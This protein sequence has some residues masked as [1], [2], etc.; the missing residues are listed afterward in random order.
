M[1]APSVSF[2]GT[3]VSGAESETDGGV[4]DEWDT[5]KSP[6]QE[7]DFV[8]SNSFSI[9]LKVGTSMNGVEL[10]ATT[11]VDYAAGGAGGADRVV[12]F[13]SIAT[14]FGILNNVGSTGMIHY[15]GSGTTTD[16]YLYY[17]HGADDYPNSGGFVFDLIDPNIAG[18]RSSTEGTPDLNAVDYYAVT[19]QFTGT[20]KAENVACDAVDYFDVG[21]GLTLIGGD[22]ASTDAVFEDFVTFDEGTTTNRYGI[23]RTVEGIL[24]VLGTLSIGTSANETDFTDE[25]GG[26]MVFP[27]GLFGPGTVGLLYDISNANSVMVTSAWSFVGRGNTTTADSRPD[28]EV[29]GAGA[30]ATATFNSCAYRNFR[31]WTGNSKATFNDCTFADGLLVT[32]NSS[33]IDGCVFSGQTTATNVAYVDSDDPESIT[34]CTFEAGANGHAIELSPTGNQTY[35]FDNLQFTGYSGTGGSAALWWNPTGGTENLVIDVTNTPSNAI[36]TSLIRNS[37]TG[38]VTVNNSVTLTLTGIQTDSEVRIINRDNTTDYNKELAGSEQIAGILVD[39]S[40]AN[41][42]TGYSVS[43]VLTVTGGTFTTAA[44]LTVTSVDSGVITGVS[45][46]TAGSYTANPSNPASVTGGL[47]SNATFNLTFAGSF[48]YSYDSSFN[49]NVAIVVFHLNYT[50]VRIL[51]TLSATSQSIPIQQGVDRVYSNP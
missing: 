11:A 21:S 37:S 40:I 16:R 25:T 7:T 32:Q 29:T 8:Y 48:Q 24:Y 1:A 26:T 31:N 49:P 47:G 12:L 20:S 19:A 2:D 14:N 33:T 22:G 51:Q 34:N 3:R 9:S 18:Y 15:I 13:K 50:E 6:T 17:T 23:V 28:Y 36:T 44:Q 39:V 43:D 42:G 46:S 38:T 45:I 30:S 41:G 35:T 27:D 5:S 10:E 4:W